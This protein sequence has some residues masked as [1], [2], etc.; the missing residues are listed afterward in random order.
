MIYI[1]IYNNYGDGRN[2]QKHVAIVQKLN[3]VNVCNKANTFK[4]IK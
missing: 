2:V 4:S 1:Y 3:Y